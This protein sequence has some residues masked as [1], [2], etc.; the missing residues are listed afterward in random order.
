MFYDKKECIEASSW[1]DDYGTRSGIFIFKKIIP[2]NLV[3]I[4]EK[5]LKDFE[6]TNISYKNGLVNWYIDKSL[7]P[8]INLIYVWEEI[9]KIIGPEYVIHPMANLLRV[10]PGDNG[11]FTHSDSPGKNMCHLLSQTD[12][13]KTCCI[14]DF[15][16]VGYFGDYEG[17]EIFY[18]NIN[19]D[20]TIK[21]N[22]NYEGPC[23]EYKPEKGDVVIHSAFNKYAH[24]VKE[25]TSGT[26]YAFSLF[27]LKTEDNPGTFYNYKSK[28]YMDQIGNKVMAKTVNDQELKKWLAPLKE[29]PQFARDKVKIMQQS[30]LQGK[31]L[32]E[33]FFKDLKE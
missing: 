11:M 1:I 5:E 12:V 31:E 19:P 20:G 23:F 32:A 2:D 17:G 9:S 6:N 4:I 28:E 8:M 27:A 33:T 22:D 21:E 24:G 18:P 3:N 26:R 15:G 7:D 14:I 13:F 16:V 30:G 29:N 25:V 10:K